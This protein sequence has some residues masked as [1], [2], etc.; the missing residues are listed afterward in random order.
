MRTSK[1]VMFITLVTITTSVFAQRHR[2]RNDRPMRDSRMSQQLGVVTSEH[3][4][5]Y[6][7]ECTPAIG[8]KSL[9]GAGSE[10]EILGRPQPYMYGRSEGQKVRVLNNSIDNSISAES[11]CVGYLIAGYIRPMTR[12][13]PLPRRATYQAVVTSQHYLTRVSNCVAP[14]QDMALVGEGAIVEVIGRPQPYTYSYTS[15]SEG[16]RVRVIQNSISN[17]ISADDG[18]EGFLINGYVRPY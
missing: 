17:S 13:I 11:G 14:I 10:V 15:A 6:T 16:I 18:C 9:V 4:M 5:I 7:T 12:E 3:Y 2:P 8:D 1:L